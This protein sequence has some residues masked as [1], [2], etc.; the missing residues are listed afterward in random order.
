MFELDLTTEKPN[1]KKSIVWKLRHENTIFQ[2]LSLDK[3][4]L[5]IQVILSLHFKVEKDVRVPLQ[6]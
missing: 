2:D 3:G 4:G 5:I 6:I 1:S